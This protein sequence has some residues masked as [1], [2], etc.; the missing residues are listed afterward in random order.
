[1]PDWSCI[2]SKWPSASA[3]AADL[4]VSTVTVRSWRGRGIP[5]RRWR[6]VVEAAKARRI[7][8]VSLEALSRIGVT[9]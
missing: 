3:L 7:K 1:M 2:I 6:D 5:A 4:G 9:A 8:G